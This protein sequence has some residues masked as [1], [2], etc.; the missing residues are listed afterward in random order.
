L[1]LSVAPGLPVISGPQ[2]ITG[3]ENAPLSNSINA[4]GA[5]TLF[6]ADSLPPGITVDPVTG[7]FSGTPIYAGEFDS[8]LWASNLWG[9]GTA[10]LHS[11]IANALL[12][13]LFIGNV[14]YNY[15]APYLLDFQFS[16]YTMSNTND[17]TTASGVVVNP[18]L[19]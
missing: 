19:L 8:T 12:G 3:V 6:G 15:S 14:T 10:N 9:V 18:K 4:S 5:P 2:L 1:L 16:L 13:N 11:S 7:N 17:P